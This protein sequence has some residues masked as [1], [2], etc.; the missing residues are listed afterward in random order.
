MGC[1]ANGIIE[2]AYNG[3]LIH[4][5]LDGE[6]MFDSIHYLEYHIDNIT[7][8]FVFASGIHLNIYEI[9][10]SGNDNSHFIF[11]FENDEW[12]TQRD[13]DNYGAYKVGA[14]KDYMMQ[15]Y[16]HSNTF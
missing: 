12:L 11:E 14:G 10:I 16:N 3:Y 2:F 4:A 1:R 15:Y 5:D 8:I 6:H 9:L 7:Q 13:G